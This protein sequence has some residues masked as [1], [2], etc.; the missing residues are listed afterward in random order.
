MPQR[1][2]PRRGRAPAQRWRLF[3][4]ALVVAWIVGMIDKVGVGVIAANNGFLTSMH[5][6]GKPTEIGLLATVMLVFYGLFMPLWGILVDR[7]GARKC[8]VAGLTLWG[9][10]ALLAASASG[11][12]V[13]LVSRAVLGAAEG[14][15]RPVSNALTARWFP[16]SERGRAK[17]IWIN[18][19][20][21]GLAVSGFLVNG[22]IGL[23]PD[24][25]RRKA[26][27]LLAGFVIAIAFLAVT[28]A[29]SG[30][31]VQLTGVIGAIV[32]VEGFATIAGQG[33]LHSIAPNER[34][35]RAIGIMSG[36]GN[37]I[38]AFGATI[39]GALSGAGGFGAAFAFLMAVFAVG[40]LA[41][42]L[43]HR[44]RY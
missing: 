14:F 15:L 12:G 39:M 24:R 31:A 6:A 20:N 33:V 40:A 4:P 22:V 35:G 32:G 9:L 16:L 13:L 17:S 25:T 36:T 26:V 23:A 3:A 19:I 42:W 8:A 43:L 11:V 27:W 28:Q 37:F 7:Y 2:L 44:A 41:A 18:G 38:A 30:V 29:S 34:M 21:V 1:G 10:S 5:L